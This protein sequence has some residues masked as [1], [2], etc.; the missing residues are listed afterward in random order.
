MTMARPI[1]RE[2]PVTTATGGL[3]TMLLDPRRCW[4]GKNLHE[5][6]DVPA[7]FSAGASRTDVEHDRLRKSLRLFGRPRFP[8]VVVEN[9][10]AAGWTSRCVVHVLRSGVDV[11]VIKQF[12]LRPKR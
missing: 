1:P 9:D 3:L 10:P 11:G 8:F 2:D 5:I 7:T 4:S 12:R 6:R